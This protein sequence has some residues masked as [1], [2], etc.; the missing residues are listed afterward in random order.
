MNTE[1]QSNENFEKNTNTNADKLRIG[2]INKSSNQDPF[3]VEGNSGFDIR[4]NLEESIVINSFERKLIPT[5]LFFEI[6]T[7]YEL[8][9]RSRSGLAI[10]YG[11]IVL[12]SPGTCDSSYKGEIKVI[13]FNSDKEPFLINNADRIA[14]GVF[15][16]VNQLFN[17][18]LVKI[19]ELS[20]TKRGSLGFG[21]SGIK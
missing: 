17:T 13:I 14:Q 5:G 12:N 10:N 2:F 1:K 18:N 15:C 20:E 4:A 11:I 6:P 3:Y 19:D 8:Q 21:S 16:Q 9:I 7:G